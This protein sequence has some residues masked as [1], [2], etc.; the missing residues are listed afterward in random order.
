MVGVLMAGVLM[1]EVLAAEGR[2]AVQGICR[3]HPRTGTDGI[4]GRTAGAVWVPAVWGA[5]CR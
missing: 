5:L 4:G 3:P 2:M 1:A